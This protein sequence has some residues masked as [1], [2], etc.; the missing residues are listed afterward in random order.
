M[1]KDTGQNFQ[2]IGSF[3]LVPK[4]P[5]PVHHILQ[6]FEG[7]EDQNG[8]GLQPHPGRH[9]A[10]E[11]EH[12]AFVAQRILDH[13]QRRLRNEDHSAPGRRIQCRGSTHS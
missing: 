13:F 1:S 10:L 4:L 7:H 2:A 6:L 9:P 11:G 8:G 12:R 3:F 5:G